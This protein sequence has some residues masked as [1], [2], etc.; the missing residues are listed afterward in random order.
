MQ[1]LSLSDPHDV[2]LRLVRHRQK[3]FRWPRFR[4][5]SIGKA[6]RR[7]DKRRYPPNLNVDDANFRKLN[8]QYTI[9]GLIQGNMPM[10]TMKKGERV[11]WYLLANGNE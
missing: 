1:S 3:T 8:L 7:G 9:N 4:N 6:R 2:R 5:R 10:M 11:R